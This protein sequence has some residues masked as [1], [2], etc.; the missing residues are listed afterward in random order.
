MTLDERLRKAAEKFRAGRETGKARRAVTSAGEPAAPCRWAEF[1]APAPCCGGMW[2]CRKEG[3][4]FEGKKGT[5]K[6]CRYACD[7]REDA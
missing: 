4:R 1:A 5:G 3:C 7:Q 6:R 2:I